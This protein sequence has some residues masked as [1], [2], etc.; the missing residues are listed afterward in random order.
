[1]SV[2]PSNPYRTPQPP[3]ERLLDVLT[4]SLIAVLAVV[5][6]LTRDGDSAPSPGDPPE[7]RGLSTLPLSHQ[8][9]TDEARPAEG[10]TPTIEQIL[11]I[12]ETE[13]RETPKAQFKEL[14]F[15]VLSSGLA[16]EGTWRENPLLADLDGDGYDD[17]VASNREEDGINVWRSLE[18]AGW[19]LIIE[20]LPRNLMYGGSDAADLDH[21]GDVDLVFAS[22][23]RSTRVFLNEGP[24]LKAVEGEEGEERMEETPLVWRELGSLESPSLA[25]DFTL[26]NL[27]GDEHHDA[28]SISQFAVGPEK[29]ALNVYLG[30]GD[31]TFERIHRLRNV[32]G[33]SRSGQQVE[34]EDIDHDGLDDLVLTAEY[35]ALVFL[36]RLAEDGTISFE[37]RSEGLPKPVNIG[38][39]FRSVVAA[40]ITGDGEL[41]IVFASLADPAIDPEERNHTGV[42][43]WRGDRWEQID[44]GLPRDR[45]FRDVEA[46]DFDGDGHTDLLLVGPWWGAVFFLGDGTGR[47]TAKGMLPGSLPGGRAALG[48]VDGDGKVDIALI[49]TATKRNRGGG[50]VNV[51]LNRDEVWE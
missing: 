32:M 3:S 39:L 49:S 14:P 7:G 10:E 47:F 17:L 44:E 51:Y 27:N 4:L 21:D 35:G 5:L 20:G 16:D 45:A 28:I 33:K 9:V 19:E 24:G 29:G 36:T 31:G 12:D 23:K 6:V 43:Q 11:G 42:Y 48:D 34:L 1:M 18:G 40:D 38:N 26:G 22:H 2:P 15:E 41:E 46:A 25:L 37:D 8:G 50:G 30:R 13:R